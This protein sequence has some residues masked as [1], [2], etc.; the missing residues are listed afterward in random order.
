L[1]FVARAPTPLGRHDHDGIEAPKQEHSRDDRGNLRHTVVPKPRAKAFDARDDDGAPPSGARSPSACVIPPPP[2]RASVVPSPTI[3]APAGASERPRASTSIRPA[4]EAHARAYLL[5][6][7]AESSV[8]FHLP[9]HGE[10]S[11]GASET[12]SVRLRDGSVEPVHARLEVLDTAVVLHGVA[13]ATFVNGSRLLAPRALCSGDQLM[14]GAVVIG[15]HCDPISEEVR[16]VDP[17]VATRALRVGDRSIVV[18]D[19]T[20]QSLFALVERL[21]ASDLPVLVSGETGAGKDVVAEAL[22][23]WSSRRGRRL[24]ALNCAAVTDTLFESELFGHERGAFSGAVAAKPGLLESADG[25]TIFL[26]EVGDCSLA[27]QAK[28]L[29]VLETKRVARVGSVVERSVDVRLVAATNRD[30][31]EDVAAGRFRRDLYYRLSAAAVIVPPLRDRPLDVPV[32]AAAL[33]DAAC[34]KL[35][36][37]P[38]RISPEAMNHLRG[39]AWPGNVRELRNLME[40]VAATEPGDRVE[41]AHVAARLARVEA[42]SDGPR[43]AVAKSGS[44]TFRNLYEEIRELERTRIAEAL[45]ATGGVRVRAAELLGVPL[46]TFVTKMKEHG[47]GRSAAKGRG[48]DDD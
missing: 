30:L 15:Y 11:I 8:A 41:E 38:M 16:A 32:L 36:R 6:I 42:P 48:R 14:L 19:P 21:S 27:V 35:G 25:G 31:E 47:I 39:H 2:E 45:A 20:M 7:E 40:Y 22:H 3:R 33:L 46:R 12:A 24:V 26:D 29:R 43:V 5:V 44:G 34:T 37:A 23:A 10:V 1:S 4:A 28:L 17:V 9:E 13:G 18:V